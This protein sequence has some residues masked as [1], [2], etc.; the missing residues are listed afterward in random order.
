MN[1]LVGLNPPEPTGAFISGSY[2]SRI[3]LF[4]SE[5]VKKKLPLKISP[6]RFCS[7]PSGGLS[8]ISVHISN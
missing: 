1:A 6:G 5:K 7:I 3:E 4:F 2:I 8:V